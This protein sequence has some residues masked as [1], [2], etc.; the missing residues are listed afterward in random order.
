MFTTVLDVVWTDDNL[1]KVLNLKNLDCIFALAGASIY[2]SLRI[3]RTGVLDRD[4]QCTPDCLKDKFVEIMTLIRRIRGDEYLQAAFE[5][6]Q[7]R[8]VERAS[9]THSTL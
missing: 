5:L 4:A 6:L 9:V 7:K 3:F 1:V 2:Y 8:L